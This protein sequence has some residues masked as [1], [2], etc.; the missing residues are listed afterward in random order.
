MIIVM[1]YF[2]IILLLVKQA[3]G[4]ELQ[5]KNDSLAKQRKYNSDS[6][7]CRWPETFLS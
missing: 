4:Q 1:A 2:F 7:V 5:N 3:E 6:R